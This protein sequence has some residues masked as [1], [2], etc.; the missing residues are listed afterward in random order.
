MTRDNTEDLDM[1]SARANEVW[2]RFRV[3]ALVRCETRGYGEFRPPPTSPLGG[4]AVM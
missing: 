2:E 4:C 3:G 1:H